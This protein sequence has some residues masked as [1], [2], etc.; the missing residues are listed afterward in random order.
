MFLFFFKFRHLKTVL[1]ESADADLKKSCGY[2]LSTVCY[3]HTKEFNALLQSFGVDKLSSSSRQ[4]SK[5]PANKSVR[6]DEFDSLDNNDQRIRGLPM[7]EKDL[8]ILSY[9]A[10]NSSCVRILL[11]T[12]FL[13]FL[14]T[15][16]S[17]LCQES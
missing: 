15:L 6:L 14:A 2:L 11:Q 1:N 17:N 9:A 12:K 13:S 4:R 16:L 3:W 7:K 10:E 5:R 8:N